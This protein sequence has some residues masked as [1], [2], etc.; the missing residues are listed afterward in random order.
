MGAQ[1][2]I[3]CTQLIFFDPCT[4]AL[5]TGVLSGT[6]GEHSIGG[7]EG[8]LFCMGATP[9]KQAGALPNSQPPTPGAGPLSVMR[10][11]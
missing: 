4:H 11:T 8:V 1:P 3:S 5:R 10:R 2:A 7:I 9:L 6:S